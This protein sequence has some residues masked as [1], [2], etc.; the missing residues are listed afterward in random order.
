VTAIRGTTRLAAVLGW[1]VE[2]SRSPQIMNAA[3][4]A[5]G[6]DAVLVPIGVPPDGLGAA[7]AGLRAMQAL[8]ASVTIPHKLA[9]A[10]LCDELSPAA[11]AI[12]AVNC[13]HIDGDQLIGHNTDE[14]GFSDGLVAAGFQIR[15]TRTVILGAGGA[16]RAVAYGMRGGRAI[17]VIAR[18]PSEVT[19]APAWPWDDEHLRDCF[20]RADLVVD[21]TSIGLGGA[22]ELTATDALPLDALPAKAWVSTLVYHRETRLLERARERGHSTVDGKRMLAHQ[23]ARAFTIWTGLPAPIEVMTRALDDDLRGT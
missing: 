3:F 17:E 6:I 9:V 8:G 4:A 7:V 14:G 22:D 18:R 21:C 12:G 15:G 13:L 20:R 2:H 10:A 19:W 16:A 11:K 1:P 23:A 5:S